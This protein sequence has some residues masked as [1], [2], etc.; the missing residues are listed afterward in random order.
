MP[1]R[2]FHPPFSFTL[3]GVLLAIL[4]LTPSLRAETF[5]GTVFYE[6]TVYARPGVSNSDQQVSAAARGATVKVISGSTELGSGPVASDGSFSFEVSDLSDFQVQVVSQS[7][8]TTVGSTLVGDILS[9]ASIYST[10]TTGTG[11]EMSLV[12]NDPDVAG[13]FNI[14]AQLE[15]AEAWLAENGHPFNSTLQVLW[16]TTEGTSY[17]PATRIIRI[18][19]AID[20]TSDPDEWD[21]DIILHEFGHAAAD[22]I[23]RDDS[24]GGAHSFEQQLDLRLSWSEGLANWISW[25]IRDDDIYLDAFL[26][27]STT[28]TSYADLSAPTTAAIETSNEWAVSYV[29]RQAELIGG[30]KAVLDT[31][32]NFTD[33]SGDTAEDDISFDTFVDLWSDG[34]IVSAMEDRHMAYEVD[35]LGQNNS[36]ASPFLLS[37]NLQELTFFPSL[38]GD[39]FSFSGNAGDV[40]TFE[41]QNT[42][43]GA[44]T[45]LR[46]YHEDDGSTQL[47]SNDQ[48]NGLQTDTT[49]MLSYT[50]PSAGNYVLEA[51]RFT[52]T[53]R[54]YG[55]AES[56]SGSDIYDRTVGRYG[57]YDL[58]WSVTRVAVEE[59]EEEEEEELIAATPED[60]LE[61]KQE[62]LDEII[63]GGNIT[64]RLDLFSTSVS[65][66]D[67]LLLEGSNGILLG[68][69]AFDDDLVEL[70]FE[71]PTFPLVL[72]GV[73]SG[74]TLVLSSQAQGLV[75]NL[76]DGATGKVLSFSLF[77]DGD[78]S[79]EAGFAIQLALEQV[80]RDDATQALHVLSDNG[81]FEDSGFAS[82]NLSGN[83]AFTMVHFSTLV[84]VETDTPEVAQDPVEED[85]I[86]ADP[87]PVITANT[88]SSGGGGGGG[89]C[90]LNP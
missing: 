8:N 60:S 25:S 54:N 22:T 75:N 90:L 85:P 77:D 33:L 69:A 18:L 6:K 38:D 88:G 87:I 11:N 7:A 31:L 5:S 76:P 79:I 20:G 36:F 12:I 40:F 26:S 41:T 89:G 66:G 70:D 35:D 73:P 13:A 68:A 65:S 3:F 15:K 32:A 47:K 86:E 72:T 9:S 49:S 24:L 39:H 27:G 63:A 43:N 78:Q 34:D 44:L 74:N 64:N 42:G 2:L 80:V 14:L 50:L 19:G 17:E 57:N 21:D 62:L 1:Q 82:A 56:N 52:S 55:L 67:N 48:A 61:T 81:F 46:V 51:A 4:A 84:L 29:L 59:E 16:P 28:L 10:T 45:S 30:T 71:D 23:S 58:E 53:T 83:L 37:D